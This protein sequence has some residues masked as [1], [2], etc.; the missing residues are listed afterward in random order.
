MI[1]S[2]PKKAIIA[3]INERFEVLKSLETLHSLYGQEFMEANFWVNKNIRVQLHNFESD[4]I[5]ETL[6]KLHAGTSRAK[7][8]VTIT[9]NCLRSS[10]GNIS[11]GFKEWD[12][13]VGI[14][15]ELEKEAAALNLGSGI[16]GQLPKI[17][18]GELEDV[19]KAKTKTL[20]VL[21]RICANLEKAE[22][23]LEQQ[24]AAINSIIKGTNIK[25]MLTN[26]KRINY[27]FSE[28]KKLY[29]SLLEIINNVPQR[30]FR[31][32]TVVGKYYLDNY[33]F[34]LSKLEKEIKNESFIEKVK[35]MVILFLTSFNMILILG[36]IK[37]VMSKANKSI[38]GRLA[39]N[40]NS[41]LYANLVLA[42][43][44]IA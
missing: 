10:M 4:T 25:E 44:N 7:Q 20:L 9:K 3:S 34:V 41:K 24:V 32:A 27:T 13:A 28:E 15:V 31:K 22:N 39:Q 17:G 33:K 1:L 12:S 11:S 23:L 26:F 36:D 5:L 29:L 16:W 38:I 40:K 42:V 8:V 35:S 43:N 30:E 21:D 37:N 19:F 18:R 14:M 2:M 6:N